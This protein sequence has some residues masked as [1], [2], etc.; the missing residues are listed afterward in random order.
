MQDGPAWW[1]PTASSA[2][3]SRRATSPAADWIS[4]RP[5]PLPRYSSSTSTDITTAASIPTGVVAKAPSRGTYMAGA[6]V[7]KPIG[8][9]SAQ[10]TTPQ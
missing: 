3:M 10:A 5:M 8:S 7:R 1:L 4:W 9:S 6:M 2:R